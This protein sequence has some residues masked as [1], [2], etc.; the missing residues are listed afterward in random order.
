M[1][2]NLFHIDW[3]R[4]FEVLLAIIVLAF[5]LERAPALLFEHCFIGIE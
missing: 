4:L 3:D 5:F 2:P 1:D